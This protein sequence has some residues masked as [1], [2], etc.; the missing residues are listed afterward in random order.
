VQ[1]T[2]NERRDMVQQN[3]Q[4]QANKVELYRVFQKELYNFESL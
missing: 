3:V 1:A 2:K 4:D